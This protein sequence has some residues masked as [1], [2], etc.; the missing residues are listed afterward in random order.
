MRLSYQIPLIT[1]LAIIATIVVNILAFQYFMGI[2]FVAYTNEIQSNEQRGILSPEKLNAVLDVS[3]LSTAKQ[4]EY[5]EVVNELSTISNSLKNISDN[6][7]L[8]IQGGSGSINATDGGYSF[9]VSGDSTAKQPFANIISFF[10]NPT[11]WNKDTPEWRLIIALLYRL[12]LTNLVVLIVILGIYF[13]WIR[14]VFIP[15]NLIIDRL[16]VYIDSSRVQKIPYQREDEFAPL[17]STINNLYKSLSVQQKIRS[18]FLSDISHEIRTPITAVRCYLEAI[19]DGMM[20]LDTKTVPL[21]QTELT[22]LTSITEQ[23]MEY[24]NLTHHYSDD[25]HV[26]RFSIKQQIESIIHEYTPQ[27]EKT[28]Q[29]IQIIKDKDVFIR[30]DRNMFIQILHNI[31]SNFIKYAGNDTILLCRYTHEKDTIKIAF[32]DNGVGIP[33]D[34]I[35]LVKEKFY[36]VNKSRTRDVNMSMGIGLS[37]IDHIVRIHDGSLEIENNIPKGLSIIMKMMR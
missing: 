12:M 28:G 5:K 30:M 22:R 17:V 34:E 19:E 6:P 18:N 25:I 32:S 13:L 8:Y 26:E 14:R 2:L 23:I 4:D 24:E 15:I 3:T 36:R 35:S 21:L 27:I 29:Q 1:G 11:P 20:Q 33:M 7:E 31:F 16:N 37:I 10:A 9:L